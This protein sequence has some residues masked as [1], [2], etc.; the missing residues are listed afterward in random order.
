M[1]RKVLNLYKESGEYLEKKGCRGRGK[2][3]S[4][5]KTQRMTHKLSMKRLHGADAQRR[6]KSSQ[7]NDFRLEDGYMISACQC[8]IVLFVREEHSYGSLKDEYQHF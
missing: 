8:V 4:S 5:E 2:F 6:L 7:S 3:L 1:A